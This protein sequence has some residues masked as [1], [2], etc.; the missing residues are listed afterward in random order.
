MSRKFGSPYIICVEPGMPELRNGVVSTGPQ[1]G[2][3][4]GM[5]FGSLVIT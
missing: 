4:S 5:K 3:G 1:F 2:P